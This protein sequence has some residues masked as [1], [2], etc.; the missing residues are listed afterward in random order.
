MLSVPLILPVV[1]VAAILPVAIP[2]GV[3]AVVLNSARRKAREKELLWRHWAMARNW[4]YASDWPEM[5]HAFRHVPFGIGRHRKA[6]RGFW[7]CFDNV[8]VFGFSYTY[9]LGTGDNRSRS[10]QFVAG[11]RFPGARFPELTIGRQTAFVTRRDIQF[12]NDE[13]NRAWFVNGPSPRFGHDVMHARAMQYLMGPVPDF[14]QM[15][16]DGDALLAAIPGDP[17]PVR[18][19]AHLRLLTQ[20]AGLLP[21][22]TLR[23]VGAAGGVTPDLSGPGISLAEQ[24]RR[25]AALQSAHRPPHGGRHR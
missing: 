24:R 3:A 21:S 25:L 11:V 17:D 20:F 22:F 2:V 8:D 16:F 19:D 7:G 9:T 1:L 12:E 23:E 5:V 13:F 10:T 14:W 15:W 4:G 6:E 18:V